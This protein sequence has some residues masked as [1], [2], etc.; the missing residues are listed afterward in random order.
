M[1]CPE[2][3]VGEIDNAALVDGLASRCVCSGVHF[4][5]QFHSIHTSWM[6]WAPSCDA[7]R[8]TRIAP[9]S[10]M[11]RP[12]GHTEDLRKPLP[13]GSCAVDLK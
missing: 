1:R 9:S 4:R 8:A 12:L 3:A 5:L 7:H 10:S 6:L 13:L 2:S 11:S